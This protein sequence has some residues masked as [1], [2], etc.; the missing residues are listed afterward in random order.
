VKCPK[1]F[2]ARKARSQM[3]EKQ[4]SFFILVSEPI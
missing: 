1:E 2:S 3:N 4:Q